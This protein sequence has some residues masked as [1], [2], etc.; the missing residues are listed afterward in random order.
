MQEK[1]AIEGKI[2]F[3]MLKDNALV[4]EINSNQTKTSYKFRR[5]FV[6]LNAGRFKCLRMGKCICIKKP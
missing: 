2:I 4:F 5:I 3:M 1:N 6:V